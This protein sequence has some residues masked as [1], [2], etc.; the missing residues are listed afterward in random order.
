MSFEEKIGRSVDSNSMHDDEVWMSG[1]QAECNIHMAQLYVLDAAPDIR[2]QWSTACENGQKTTFQIL[3]GMSQVQ[4][5]LQF[6]I[7]SDLNL[8][9]LNERLCRLLAYVRAVLR[10]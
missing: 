9:D 4:Q 10:F 5:L 7:L 2:T 6:L 1:M 3:P 8:G